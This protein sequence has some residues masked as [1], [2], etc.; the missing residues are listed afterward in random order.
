MLFIS[1]IIL[2]FD[3]HKFPSGDVLI[4]LYK[5]NSKGEVDLLY[6]MECVEAREM[7]SVVANSEQAF[8]VGGL[9]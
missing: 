3:T 2:L 4:L 5:V 6:E 8:I 9:Y 7:Y 1:K